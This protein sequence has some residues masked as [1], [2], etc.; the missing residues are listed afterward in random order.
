[1]SSDEYLAN[2]IP[3]RRTEKFYTVSASS[4]NLPMVGASGVYIVITTDPFV[5]SLSF[6][7]EN[8]VSFNGY[9]Y[10]IVI[11]AEAWTTSSMARTGPGIFIA[12]PYDVNY[13]IKPGHG[14]APTPPLL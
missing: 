10:R 13:Q 5:G 9:T 3:S 12:T 14:P 4:G 6:L 7:S 1:M 2:K 11:V 8:T